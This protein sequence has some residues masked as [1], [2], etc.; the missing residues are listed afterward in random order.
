MN[1]LLG[2]LA[3]VG[4]T[5]P[6]VATI[7]NSNPN[8]VLNNNNEYAK[9]LLKNE[10]TNHT[11][12]D[13]E[14]V[15][16]RTTEEEIIDYILMDMLNSNAEN[17]IISDALF[18]VIFYKEDW[19]FVGMPNTIPKPGEER[20]LVIKIMASPK[21]ERYSGF[22]TFDLTLTNGEIIPPVEEVIKLSD[23]IKIKNLGVFKNPTKEM[24]VNR[25]FEKNSN[26]QRDDVEIVDVSY[27][28]LEL[29]AK[30][31]RLEGNATVLFESEIKLAEEWKSEKIHVE[32]Y[33]STKTD[34][35]EYNITY[36]IEFGFTK[37]RQAFK[38]VSFNYSGE[39]KC[40]TFNED[41]WKTVPKKE[42]FLDFNGQKVELW[43]ESYYGGVNWNKTLATAEINSD[44]NDKENKLKLKFRIEVAAK[45]NWINAYYARAGAQLNIEDIHFKK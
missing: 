12:S 13:L 30:S 34:S 4:I 27:K 41:K 29:K 3:T 44:N 15:N 45:A 37:L 39:Y 6:T 11:T 35:R 26:I 1:F 33:N 22:M 8:N 18:D 31:E 10:K 16:I 17:E 19:K 20:K 5:S 43:N 21:N 36:D 23:A 14:W 25:F 32:A 2:M 7:K 40:K 28:T 42:T 24:I 9:I 38:G